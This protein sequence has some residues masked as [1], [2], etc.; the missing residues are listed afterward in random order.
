MEIIK[1]L[2]EGARTRPE[3]LKKRKEK[4]AKIIGYTGRFVPEELIYAAGAEPYF[5]C[6]GGEP[7]PAEELLPY[8]LRVI[9]PHA[10]AQTGYHLLAVE[11]VI[12][13]L[14]LII[15]ECSDCHYVRLADVMEY[16]KLPTVRLGVPADWTKSISFDYYHRGLIKLKER[17]EAL[18]GNKISDGKL[19]EATESLNKIRNVLRKISELRKQQPPPIG[20]YGFIQLNHYS[21]YCGLEEQI[22]GLNDLYGQLKE[23]KSPFSQGAPR[24][25]LA[26]RLVSVGDYV[27]SKLIE[28]LGGVVVAEF[29]DEGHRQ[30]RWEVEA[31][32]NLLQNIAETYFLK[33]TPPS[34][35]QPAWED[36]L[37]YMKKLVEDY[38]IDGVIWYQLSFE[39]IYDMEC[40]IV[41]R[42][43]EEMKVPFLKL[44]SSYEYSR[45]A[46]GPL[47]TRVESFIES[48]KL[49]KGS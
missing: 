2:A 49:K 46:M 41:S 5:I 45:E 44:E 34:I 35:F 39:E 24:L 36:R 3:E 11:P 26:G 6:R 23:S 28:T 8:M 1:Q 22:A 43:M 33:R 29:L 10:R 7:E 18:T 9:N 14:D 17:L 27:L 38:S 25:L 4:G 20:G 42:A 47:T 37:G 40:S 48:I 30:C 15:A 21:F 19:K 16:F 31:E 13:M 12:P 32:G